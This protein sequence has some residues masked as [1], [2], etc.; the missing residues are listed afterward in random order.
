VHRAPRLR[1]NPNFG[2]G[3]SVRDKGVDGDEARAA[4][5]LAHGAHDL[6]RE[7]LQNALVMRRQEVDVRRTVSEDVHDGPRRFAVRHEEDDLDTLAQ[8]R[9]P[10]GQRFADFGS[11]ECTEAHL[12]APVATEVA[13][14]R[15]RG[16]TPLLR[17]TG[18]APE[19]TPIRFVIGLVTRA[20]EHLGARRLRQERGESAD[21]GADRLL[22]FD[23][24]APK[25]RR[26]EVEGRST[27]VDGR[28]ARESGQF[29][30]DGSIGTFRVPEAE[31][32]GALVWNKRPR[33][34]FFEYTKRGR[35]LAAPT[36]QHGG[37]R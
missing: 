37:L 32:A 3:A 1:Q 29:G 9:R 21:V 14:E 11:D 27:A 18:R 12:V 20:G 28:E 2:A 13:T 35:G 22:L 23:F 8:R 5:A 15:E 25:A 26:E 31:P 6:K 17:P 33:G 4:P 36:W 16:E 10:P 30:H 19:V 34:F 7:S 24:G